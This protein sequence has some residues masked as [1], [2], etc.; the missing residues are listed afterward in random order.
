MTK[1]HIS[2]LGFIFLSA[3]VYQPIGYMRI[4]GAKLTSIPPFP[5]QFPFEFS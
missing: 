3:F 4:S 2:L 5:L 1:V